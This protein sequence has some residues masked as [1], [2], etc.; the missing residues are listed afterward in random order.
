MRIDELFNQRKPVISFEI[1]PPKKVDGI[2]T[3]YDTLHELG[4][5]QAD[6]V[7]V[8]YGA[9][10][11]DNFNRTLEISK[12]VQDTFKVPALHH[13]TCAERSITE[14]DD[15]FAQLQ[16]AG[17]ENI[18]ALRGDA[19]AK[20]LELTD[21]EYAKDLIAAVSANGNF[22]TGAACYPEGHVSQLKECEDMKHLRQKANAGANFFISQLFFNNDHFYRL[23][24]DAF[25]NHIEKPISAGIMPILSQKQVARMTFMCGSSLPAKLVKLVHQ[26]GD[27]PSDLQAAGIEYALE[28]ARDLIEQGVD[29]VHIYAMNRSDV[30]QQII[31][32][33]VN[34][35]GEFA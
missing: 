35:T 12:Y 11:S 32:D 19:T 25:A 15:I 24:E 6:F 26:Y 14:M 5:V 20:Q 33:L 22:S 18:L 1:F 16:E 29:G 23:Q 27:K 2:E 34:F 3:L 17:I 28:Q 4:D 9:G 10:S 7:S 31:P 8:T 30:I 13:L 21:Y